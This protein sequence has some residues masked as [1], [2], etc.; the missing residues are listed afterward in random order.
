M[1]AGFGFLIVMLFPKPASCQKALYSIGAELAF[2]AGNYQDIGNT[3]FGGSIQVENP[4]SKH[5]SGI[6]SIEYIHYSYNEYFGTNHE[7]F[8]I[9]PI[10]FGV[11]Y[12]T[13]GRSA[14]PAGFY[15]SG[16]LGLT[17]EFYHVII[18]FTNNNGT[19]D[20]HE[21]Y[22]GFCNT[23]G[24]GYQLGILDAGFRFQTLASSNTGFT[25]YYNFR[26]AFTIL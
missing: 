23:M 6:L 11:K 14:N 17:G 7:Q 4:W 5:V 26:L 13:T 24:L 3:G 2:P 10:Q 12:Y 16:Q 8:S 9:L 19:Y 15:L 20:T 18:I 25:S 1:I 22:L 21:H